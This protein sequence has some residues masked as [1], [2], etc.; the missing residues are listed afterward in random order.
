MGIGTDIIDSAGLK[1]GHI[2]WLED[3]DQK[4]LQVSGNP[5]VIQGYPTPGLLA[6]TGQ[7]V[8]TSWTV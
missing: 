3:F 6:L 1:L 2:D 7:G 8:F 5:T 4:E